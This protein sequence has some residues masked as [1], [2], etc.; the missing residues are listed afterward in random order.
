MSVSSRHVPSSGARCWKEPNGKFAKNTSPTRGL[1]RTRSGRTVTQAL[2]NSRTKTLCGGEMTSF[3]GRS[4]SGCKRRLGSRRG[5][6]ASAM[7]E[8]PSPTHLRG[9]ACF[10]TTRTN[11]RTGKRPSG[12]AVTGSARNARHI[13]LPRRRHAS[14]VNFLARP[15]VLAVALL[16]RTSSGRPKPR[17]STLSRRR[18]GKAIGTAQRAAPTILPKTRAASSAR[19]PRHYHA[20]RSSAGGRSNGSIVPRRQWCRA[21]P[22]YPASRTPSTGGTTRWRGKKRRVLVCTTGGLMQRIVSSMPFRGICR[23]WPGKIA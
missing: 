21:G 6:S 23:N 8:R 4:R 14:R 19:A 20:T 10:K 11:L 15:L 12:G 2:N 9:L 3:S 22:G 17:T 13:T 7:S 5:C 18:G 16:H 1:T